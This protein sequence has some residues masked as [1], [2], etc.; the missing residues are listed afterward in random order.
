MVDITKLTLGEFMRVG[1]SSMA[2]DRR[3]AT[4]IERKIEFPGNGQ[5][6]PDTPRHATD[7]ETLSP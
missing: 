2:D 4:E 1:A 3:P 6:P 7:A 5:I